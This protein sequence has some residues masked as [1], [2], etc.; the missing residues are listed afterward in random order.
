MTRRDRI[1]HILLA[2]A[3]QA[4]LVFATMPA[5]A[6]G[7]PDLTFALQ[8]SSSDGKTVVPKLTWST[9]P[10]ATSCSAAGATN[11][12]GSK[13]ASGTVTLAAVSASVTY[14]LVCTWPGVTKAAITWT[15]PTTNVDG[16]PLT[17]LA[18]FRVQYGSAGC[19]ED[20]LDQSDYVRD[21]A[22]K[23]WTSPDLTA[24]TWCFAVRA[25]NAMGLEG[26]LSNTGSKATTA[27]ASQN[28]AL[29][30]AIKFPGA[31]VL[32]PIL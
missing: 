9:T 13:A 30:L 6:Q 15:A 26:P 2:L 11:W 20:K 14:S 4:L 12:T 16:S 23:A 3:V 32:N 7:S 1:T 21:A 18:G 10:A 8:A 19:T 25:Y 5:H 22:G 17:N 31:P 27:A 24:G 29:E 28:R